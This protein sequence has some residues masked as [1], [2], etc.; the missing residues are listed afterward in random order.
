MQA[1]SRFQEL[2]QLRENPARQA[3][4]ALSF[5]V[6]ASGAGGRRLLILALLALGACGFQLRGWDQRLGLE[7]VHVEAG[8][9]VSAAAP[10]RRALRQAGAKLAP[11]PADAQLTAALLDER[12]DLRTVSVAGGAVAAEYEVTLAVHYAIRAGAAKLGEPRWAEA[13]R[14]YVIDRNSVAGSAEEQAL[15]E[16]ELVEDIVQEILRALNAAAAEAAPESAEQRQAPPQAAAL[17]GGGA[18]QR[19]VP[20]NA[21]ADQ[22]LLERR[23]IAADSLAADADQA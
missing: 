6:P 10:L 5:P 12:R 4:L 23:R 13:R 1:H 2:A 7:S 18:R 8:A 15:I 22:Y 16:A 21:L 20:A 3:A 17:H 19:P 9:Q 14:V 11:S